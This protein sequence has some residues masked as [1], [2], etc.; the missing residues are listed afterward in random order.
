MA[1]SSSYR[2]IN[3]N[4]PSDD[5]DTPP[6]L[7]TYTK[8]AQGFCWNEELFL[9]SYLMSRGGRRRRGWDGGMD[10]DKAVEVVEIHIS[11]DEARA[12]MP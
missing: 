7:I 2:S 3:L 9:P 8:A 5:P 1:A 12:M 10:D 4:S 6:R 11:D